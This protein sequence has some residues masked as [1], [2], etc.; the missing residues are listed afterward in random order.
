MS[1]IANII[2]LA[3]FAPTEERATTCT[4]G[5]EVAY[6]L[7]E[8]HTGLQYYLERPA[9]P[10]DLGWG[11][12]GRDTC[13]LARHN[14]RTA[15]VF[16]FVDPYGGTPKLTIAIVERDRVVEKHDFLKVM[17]WDLEPVDIRATRRG[18]WRVAYR[19]GDDAPIEHITLDRDGRR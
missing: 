11:Y 13:V 14:R 8:Q 9:G 3:A 15:V 7:R 6:A 19:C 18:G 17:C 16:P 5:R 2:M 1:R 4:D 12:D 10:I